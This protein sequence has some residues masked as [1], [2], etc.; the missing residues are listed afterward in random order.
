[1][2]DNNHCFIWPHPRSTER[3]LKN[4]LNSYRL[5]SSF[6][7]L[8][9]NT[10]ICIQSVMRVV[11]GLY[12]R[13]IRQIPVHISSTA[14]FLKRLCWLSVARASNNHGWT[15]HH[16]FLA[17]RGGETVAWSVAMTENGLSSVLGLKPLFELAARVRIS[18]AKY[19]KLSH[20]IDNM[21]DRV[22]S[23]PADCKSMPHLS[24]LVRRPHF[25]MISGRVWFPSFTAMLFR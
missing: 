9:D 7:P 12:Y 16:V 8:L 19:Q 18:C 11:N 25:N 15:M 24:P 13:L 2:A 22:S 6:V 20:P 17:R 23:Y 4:N 3:K 5:F 1:M 10:L 14:P 21:T